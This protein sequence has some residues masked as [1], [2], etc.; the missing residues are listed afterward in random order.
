MR[1]ITVFDG[2]TLIGIAIIV[3]AT[4]TYLIVKAIVGTYRHGAKVVDRAMA[5]RYVVESKEGE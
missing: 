2:M 1:F 4:V 3:V 5:D